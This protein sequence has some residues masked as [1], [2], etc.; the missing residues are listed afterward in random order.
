MHSDDETS[1]FP[2]QESKVFF[3]SLIAKIG[4]VLN[5]KKNR[6][7]KVTVSRLLWVSDNTEIKNFMFVSYSKISKPCAIM[8]FGMD[9]VYNSYER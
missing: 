4:K 7:L 3:P 1:S 2:F 9:I 8:S 5:K 6:K